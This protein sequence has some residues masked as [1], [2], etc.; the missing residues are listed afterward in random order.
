[1]SEVRAPGRLKEGLYNFAAERLNLDVELRYR[2]VRRALAPFVAQGTS[3]LEVGAG[4]VSIGRY[5]RC[6]VTAVDTSFDLR[7][8]SSSHRVRGSACSLPFCDQAWDVVCSID[9]L[10]HIPPALRAVAISEMVR[11]GRRVVVLAVPAG[12]QAYREDVWTHEYYVQHHGSP[13]RFAKEHVEYGLPSREGIISAFDDAATR[14][15]RSLSLNTI[16]NLNL[17]LRRFYMKFALRSSLMIR[18]FYVGMFPLA[19][20]GPISDFGDCYRDIFVA[21]LMR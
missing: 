19:Y 9:M 6:K 4:A 20:L 14:H 1:M 3:V 21:Q 8:N 13:H 10:E 15:G 5:L 17:S 12:E 16:P 18:A 7:R 2:A 11:V